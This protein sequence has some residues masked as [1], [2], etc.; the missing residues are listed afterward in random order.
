MVSQGLDMVIFISI[1]FYGVVSSGIFLEMIGAQYIAKLLFALADTPFCYLLV[2]WT[3]G[4]I[5]MKPGKTA[6]ARQ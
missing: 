3:K 5:E 2:G 4:R 1:T 6:E